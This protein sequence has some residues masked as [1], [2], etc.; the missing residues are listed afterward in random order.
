M[1]QRNSP[2]HSQVSFPRWVTLSQSTSLHSCNFEDFS[3]YTAL[4]GVPFSNKG[5]EPPKPML[6]HGR[7]NDCTQAAIHCADKLR[8]HRAA[9]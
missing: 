4:L 3:W 8:V 1:N 6:H 9:D 2:N 7:T 5:F